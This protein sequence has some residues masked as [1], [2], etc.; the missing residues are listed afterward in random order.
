MESA[1]V[2]NQV[3]GGR[4]DH[5][6]AAFRLPPATTSAAEL[7]SLRNGAECGPFPEELQGVGAWLMSERRHIRGR[8]ARARRAAQGAAP[9]ARSR[10][11]PRQ[12]AG[13]STWS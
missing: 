9:R 8:A 2:H 11:T 7:G 12:D 13:R 3:D 6:G 10:G 5:E 4:S 1:P